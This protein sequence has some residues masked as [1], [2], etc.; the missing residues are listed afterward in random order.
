M[1]GEFGVGGKY[2][3]GQRFDLRLPYVDQ[4]WVDESSTLRRKSYTKKG[5]K[6]AKGAPPPK[7]N[8]WDPKPKPPPKARQPAASKE[9]P[10]NPLEWW[11]QQST[12]GQ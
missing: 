1:G 4:G 6:A 3:N 12:K 10:K 8:W 2:D 5:A 7:R 11:I 9:P